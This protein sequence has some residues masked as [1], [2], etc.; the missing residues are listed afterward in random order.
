M[1]NEGYTSIIASYLAETVSAKG[2]DVEV[3]KGSELLSGFTL[4]GFDNNEP[5]CLLSEYRIWKK[6]KKGPI[7]RVREGSIGRRTL[8]MG[9]L[10]ERAANRMGMRQSYRTASRMQRRRSWMESKLGMRQDFEPKEE[11]PAQA[12]PPAAPAS[13]PEPGYVAELERLAQ[14]REQGIVS[15]EEFAAKKKQLLG[16]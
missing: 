16:I 7:K 9:L 2:H 4:E 3:R 6:W 8:R 12:A 1:S 10:A 15:E 14:L 5:P 11:E 13:A